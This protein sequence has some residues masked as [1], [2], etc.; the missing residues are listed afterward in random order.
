MTRLLG[1]RVR[2]VVNVVAEVTGFDPDDLT[3]PGRQR[4]VSHARHIACWVAYRC[5]YGASYPLV[6]YVLQR[7]HTTVMNSVQRVNNTPELLE[8][9]ELI[10]QEVRERYNQ[11][12]QGS[13]VL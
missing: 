3:G 8:M 9:A 7:D 13:M 11:S 10:A 2:D 6:G 1:P 12:K 5:G 4:D